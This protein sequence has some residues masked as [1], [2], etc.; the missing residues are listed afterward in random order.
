[1]TSYRFPPLREDVYT[2]SIVT[3]QRDSTADTQQ[4]QETPLIIQPGDNSYGCA[5]NAFIPIG[6]VRFP[7]GGIG[8]GTTLTPDGEYCDLGIRRSYICFPSLFRTQEEAQADCVGRVRDTILLGLRWAFSTCDTRLRNNCGIQIA[9]T[10]YDN[11]NKVQTRRI[12]RCLNNSCHPTPLLPNVS[13]AREAT[14]V[15]SEQQITCSPYETR[16]T[17]EQQAICGSVDF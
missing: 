15:P 14:Y 3:Q 1:M 17:P 12:E 7:C 10:S 6:C 2:T 5:C 9:C 13:N 11:N 16:L 4:Q 8:T